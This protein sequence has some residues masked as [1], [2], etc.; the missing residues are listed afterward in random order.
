MPRR[1]RRSTIWSA[2]DGSR[3][4]S[5]LATHEAYQLKGTYISS[6]PTT[7]EDLARHEKYR[8]LF[9]S[10]LAAEYPE[11]IARLFTLVFAFGRLVKDEEDRAAGFGPHALEDHRR[12][13]RHD[14]AFTRVRDRDA[15]GRFQALR[16]GE[17]IPRLGPG[18]PVYARF[19]AGRE[20][21][22]HVPRGALFSGGDRER[23][24]HRDAGATR[25][26][27]AVLGDRVEL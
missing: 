3:S 17:H 6:R 27:P 2:T 21:R 23:T 18:M 7:D 11:V 22:F 16:T 5:R 25:G 10:T 13:L 14:S 19:H 1:G 9:A 12:P 20:D 4:A 15:F 24:D 8:A 26:L